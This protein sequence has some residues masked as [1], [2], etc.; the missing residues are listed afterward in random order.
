MKILRKGLIVSSQAL[1]GNPLKNSESLAVMAEAAEKGGAVAIRAN[2]YL[3][4]IAMKNRVT[5]PVI[6]LNKLKDKTGATI[7]TP[8]FESAKEVALAGADIIAL[9]AT[10]RKSEIKDDVQT[11]IA[12]IHTELRLPVLADISTAEEAIYAEKAGA[13]YVSTTLAGYTQEKPYAPEEKYL[14]DFEVIDKILR[15]GIKIPVI[16]EGRFWKASDVAQAMQMGCHGIV[17]GKA[18]TNPMAITE[19]F[20]Q[21]VNAGLEAR[22]A[23]PKTEDRNDGTANI[24][25]LSTYDILKKINRE[26]DAVAAKVKAALPAIANAVDAI[27][28]D[29]A[30]GGRLLYCGA[31]TSGRLAVADAAE[32]APTYGVTNDRVV[33]TMAGGKEAVFNASENKE[34]SYEDGVLAAKKLGLRRQD[35]IIAISANGNAQFCL[36][37]MAFAKSCGAKTIALTNNIGTKMAENADYSI[38]ILTGAEVIKGSTRMKAGTAQKMTLNMISTALFIKCGCVISN[39]MVN[40]QPNN[41]KLKNRA[42]SMLSILTD[43]DEKDC[44]ALLEENGWSIRAA[45]NELGKA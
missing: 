25:A 35:A 38:E 6:A 41:V 26:D 21:A 43:K 24:D 29:F 40:I 4:V 8:N 42:V 18:V 27:Y 20:C 31:G 22:V 12:R 16:A 5:V 13:D 19:Y 33:A 44:R 45:L 14:P 2:G 32:C 11:L 7:I 1:D 36:G 3:N 28:P 9:D 10:F 30:N 34:D 17:I 37:F 23:P 15:S 39:L